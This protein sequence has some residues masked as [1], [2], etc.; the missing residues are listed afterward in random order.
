MSKTDFH[1][2][3]PLSSPCLSLTFTSCSIW[4]T[5]REKTF[6]HCSTSNSPEP[7]GTPSCNKGEGGRGLKPQ[8]GKSPLPIGLDSGSHFHWIFCLWGKASYYTNPIT[9]AKQC[10]QL[11]INPT[12]HSPH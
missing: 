4:V 6:N 9:G 2:H 7:S 1:L 10:L 5:L 8:V 11:G 3:A 12:V